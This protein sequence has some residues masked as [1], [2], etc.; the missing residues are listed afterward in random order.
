MSEQQRAIDGG[1][2]R[3]HDVPGITTGM[4]ILQDAVNLVRAFNISAGEFE[5]NI[6]R[7]LLGVD[8]LLNN[9]IGPLSALNTNAANVERRIG[10]V[11]RRFTAI[12]N[13]VRNNRNIRNNVGT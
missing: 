9:H 12:E 4:R 1:G 13:P 3:Y 10:T 11:E 5:A 8:I 2:G 7:Q 6:P